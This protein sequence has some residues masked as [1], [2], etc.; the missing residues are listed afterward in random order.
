MEIPREELLATRYERIFTFVAD[1]V[2]LAAVGVALGLLFTVFG[3]PEIAVAVAGVVLGLVWWPL[4]VSRPG[5]RNGQTPAKQ[6]LGLRTM[7]LDGQP[8][9]F[10]HAFVREGLIKDLL[11]GLTAQLFLV[12]SWALSLG[13]DDRQALHDRMVGTIVVCDATR[14]MS[15]PADVVPPLSQQ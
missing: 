3:M 2:I 12:V 15:P 1:L 5:E 11:G 14:W 6:L 4:F 7:R 10:E 8:M 13:R 9:T